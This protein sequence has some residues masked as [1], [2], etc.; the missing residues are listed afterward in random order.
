MDKIVEKLEINWRLLILTSKH[1]K[2]PLSTNTI[3][4]DY[5][6]WVKFDCLKRTAFKLR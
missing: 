1:L 2:L 5:E 3:E 6:H 4:Y